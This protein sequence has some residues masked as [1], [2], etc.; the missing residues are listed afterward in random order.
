M[1]TAPA[2]QQAML[3]EIRILRQ[4][5]EKDSAGR[6]F[7]LSSLGLTDERILALLTEKL[8][9]KL[10][11][12]LEG[13]T[14]NYAGVKA[15][16]ETML[17]T[18][19]RDERLLDMLHDWREKL[20][21]RLDLTKFVEEWLTCNIQGSNPVWLGPLNAFVDARIDEFVSS[22]S[23]Q[24]RFD[25]L[26]KHF[27]ADELNRHHE[28]IPGLIRER[29]NEFSD[30]DLVAFVEGKVEDDLQMIRINGAIVGSMVGMG[31]YLVVVVVERMWGL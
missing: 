30:D 31:L 17:R 22:V 26:L 14:Q 18:L 6:A 20:L 24:Q 16:L 9:S 3:Q 11:E 13:K 19:G 29:L 10:N 1:L 12:C 25:E 8:G 23:A 27:L 21:S 4:N 2:F 5:Y 15:G 28:L 7:V